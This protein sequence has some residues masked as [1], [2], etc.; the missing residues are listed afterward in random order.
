MLSHLIFIPVIKIKYKLNEKP[1]KN[2]FILLNVCS[3]KIQKILSKNSK[4]IVILLSSV[5]IICHWLFN[6]RKICYEN[7]LM[8]FSLYRRSACLIWW[9][10]KLI[11][12]MFELILMYWKIAKN[13]HSFR[14]KYFNLVIFESTWKFYCRQFLSK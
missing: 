13:Q 11:Q 3:V 12:S 1:F 2:K 5:N 9:L 6:W 14:L 10:S 7:Y 4:L 8:N